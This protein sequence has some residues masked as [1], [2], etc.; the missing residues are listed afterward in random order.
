[1][2]C[3]LCSTFLRGANFEAKLVTA[4]VALE[5]VMKCCSLLYWDYKQ[6]EALCRP[7]PST[8]LSCFSDG[9][10]SNDM[11]KATTLM[12]PEAL[13]TCMSTTSHKAPSAD[14]NSKQICCSSYSSMHTALTPKLD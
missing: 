5:K 3:E 7:K 14:I 9:L 1:M 11:L 6:K 12:P 13:G 8:A 2:S 4:I 10:V